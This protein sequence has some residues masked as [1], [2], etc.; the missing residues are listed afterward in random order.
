MKGGK[1]CMNWEPEVLYFNEKGE[2]IEVS[3]ME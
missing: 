3:G 1:L 2:E